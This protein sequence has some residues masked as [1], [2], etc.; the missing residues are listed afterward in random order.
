MQ[1]IREMLAATGLTEQQ[2]RVLRV[3]SEAGP[4]DATEVS[5][6]AGL[7]LPSL[8]RMMRAMAQKGLI[9]RQQD[10]VD[11]RRQVLAITPTGQKIIDD[12]HLHALRIVEGFKARMGAE[13]YEE[14]L[15]LLDAFS[16]PVDQDD[17]GR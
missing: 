8:T 2:W 17:G 7:L 13:K 16:A 1:P 6:R 3:L 10:P 11:R 14:L 15:D 5:D 4:V 9:T 12:N